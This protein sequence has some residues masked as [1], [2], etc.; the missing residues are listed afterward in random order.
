[1]VRTA[2]FSVNL[3][4]EVKAPGA[5]LLAGTVGEIL[6]GFAVLLHHLLV[7]GGII[8]LS[9]W[10]PVVETRLRS[11]VGEILYSGARDPLSPRLSMV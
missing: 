4:S 9:V 2:N 10:S 6:W 11:K 5:G 7:F 1:M 3:T 8:S